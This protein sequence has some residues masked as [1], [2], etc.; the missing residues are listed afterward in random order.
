MKSKTMS[1]GRRQFQPSL[2][3][4]AL[5]SLFVLTTAG[6]ISVTGTIRAGVTRTQTIHLRAGWNA[7][8][9]EVQPSAAKPVDVFANLPVESAAC[10]LPGRQEAQY[11]RNPGDAPWREDGWAVWYAPG[12]PEAFLSNLFWVQAMR[13]LLVRAA[14]D[15]TWTVIGESRATTLAWHAN[16][17]TFTGLPVDPVAPPTFAQFFSGSSAHQRFRIYRLVEGIWKL[18]SDPMRDTVRSGEAY[19][20]Q[21]DGASTYQG[22]LRLKLPASGELD[23]DLTGNRHTL[24]FRNESAASSASVK[25]ESLGGA[26]PLPLR[27]VT[28]DLEKLQTS[29]S[30]LPSLTELPALAPKA[31]ASLEIEPERNAI[32]AGRAGTLLRITDGRGT[33][34]W[35]P[36]FAR[37]SAIAQR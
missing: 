23:F 28:R 16:T 4:R 20:I 34:M 18:I 3:R 15:C 33:Q 26:N 32:T 24:E 29:R 27:R 6:F 8:F 17:C 19:W 9:L 31:I 37:R 30:S 14:S 25:I 5:H 13:P 2:K 10:F 35:V 7:V 12:K 1:I 36:V 21:T 22:P 11:L